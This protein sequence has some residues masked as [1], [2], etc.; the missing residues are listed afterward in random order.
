M[1]YYYNIIGKPIITSVSRRRIYTVTDDDETVEL[2][3]KIIGNNIT[4]AYFERLNGT[5]PNVTN[6]IINADSNEVILNMSFKAHP[7]NSG[8]FQCIVYGQWGVTSSTIAS[9]SIVAAPP[10]FTVHPTDKVATALENVTFKAEAKGFRVKFEWIFYNSSGTY[11]IGTEITNK[12]SST[13]TLYR[14]TPSNAGHYFCVAKSHGKNHQVFSRN[15]TLTVNGNAAISNVYINYHACCL[16]ADSFTVK[17]NSEYIVGI[18]GS[19]IMN[20]VSKG[21]GSAY[22]KYQW[23]KVGSDPLPSTASGQDTPNLIINEVKMT[24]NGSYVCHVRNSWG[25][26]VTSNVASMLVLSK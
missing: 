3:C 19:V 10:T 13:L 20:V 9:V 8:D 24:D 25:T 14:V 4:L 5:L 22:Y 2:V 17:L 11:P 18:N 23:E 16:L 15:V 12:N 26:T 21:P 7:H 1:N 6:L